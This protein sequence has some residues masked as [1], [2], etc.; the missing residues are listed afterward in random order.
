V[1]DNLLKERRV[2]RTGEER[3]DEGEGSREEFEEM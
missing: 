1:T 2:R 3:G